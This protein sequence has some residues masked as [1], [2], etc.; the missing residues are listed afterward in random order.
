VREAD[1]YGHLVTVGSVGLQSNIDGDEKPLYAGATNDLLQWHLYGEKTY[2]PHAHALEMARKVRE[3]YGYGKPVFCGEFGYG[4]EDPRFFD[5]THTGIWA[6]TFAGGGALAHSAPPFNLDS[7]G[8][9]TPER[10]HHFRVLRDVLASLDWSRRLEP[11]E[12]VVAVRPVGA[13]VFALG[14]SAY[15]ALWVL[16]PRSNYGATV[17]GTRLSVARLTP[18]RYRVTWRNDV[19]GE[20]VATSALVAA[21]QSTKVDVPA[22]ARHIFG[23]IEPAATSPS[24]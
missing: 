10:G 24:P 7:D 21:A 9:M 18:G 5:H 22:F 14:E 20:I 1:P 12:S 11:D 23:V 2:H 8:P 16:A 6:A 4:G 15:K 13:H 3:T 17:A 19:S